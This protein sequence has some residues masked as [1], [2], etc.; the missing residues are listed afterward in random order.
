MSHDE[1]THH[2]MLPNGMFLNYQKGQ[3]EV[4]G[5]DVQEP[6]AIKSDRPWP[7]TV[8]SDEAPPEIGWDDEAGCTTCP[9][10]P[11]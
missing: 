9:R 2:I 7:G 5:K 8:R 10:C 1:F 6:N 4:C 11:E 3:C